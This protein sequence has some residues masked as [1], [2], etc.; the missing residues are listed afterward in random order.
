M[1]ILKL[2]PFRGIDESGRVGSP[3]ST[4]NSRGS[5]ISSHNLRR[6]VVF[7][8]FGSGSYNLNNIEK[9]VVDLS[10]AVLTARHFIL[11]PKSIR[12]SL[13]NKEDPIEA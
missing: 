2:G 11:S 6:S 5:I 13:K 9:G 12:K 1:S 4:E 7:I 3:K 10:N 8:P